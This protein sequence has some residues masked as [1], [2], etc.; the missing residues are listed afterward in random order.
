MENTSGR[1]VRRSVA[2]LAKFGKDKLGKEELGSVGPPALQVPNLEKAGITRTARPH[3]RTQI[4]QTG[5]S[6]GPL[7]NLE[8]EPGTVNSYR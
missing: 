6:G 1:Q 4:P 8:T 3:F 7:P 2:T 5:R